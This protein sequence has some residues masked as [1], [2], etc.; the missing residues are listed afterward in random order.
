MEKKE[1]EKPFSPQIQEVMQRRERMQD[2]AGRKTADARMVA[3][4]LQSIITCP[5]EGKD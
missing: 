1:K 3:W 4:F 2:I 5:T